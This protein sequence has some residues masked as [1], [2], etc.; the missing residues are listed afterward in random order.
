MLSPV[1][2]H[3]ADLKQ[4]GWWRGSPHPSGADAAVCSGVRVGTREVSCADKGGDPVTFPYVLCQVM[5]L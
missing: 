3:P 5:A 1:L 4:S 2:V